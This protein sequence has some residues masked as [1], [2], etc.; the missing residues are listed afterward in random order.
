MS[1]EA[2]SR[3]KPPRL[4]LRYDTRRLETDNS[5]TTTTSTTPSTTRFA[6]RYLNSAAVQGQFHSAWSVCMGIFVSIGLLCGLIKSLK[7][8][9]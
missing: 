6:V 8:K 7:W 2:R 3:I 1:S 5:E 4:H 9:V